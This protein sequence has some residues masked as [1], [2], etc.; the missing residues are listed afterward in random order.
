MLETFDLTRLINMVVYFLIT[1]SL[2]YLLSK[3]YNHVQLG[4]ILIAYWIFDT[5]YNCIL[6]ISGTVPI[7]ALPYQLCT[8]TMIMSAVAIRQKSEKLYQ[9]TI[10]TWISAL[11]SM[12][13][14]TRNGLMP[15]FDYHTVVFYVSHGIILLMQIYMTRV[16]R[17]KL[18]KYSFLNILIF[19]LLYSFSAWIINLFAGTNF[20]FISHPE[21]EN[22]ILA[23]LGTG[24]IYSVKIFFIGVLVLFIDELIIKFVFRIQ[25]HRYNVFLFRFFSGNH[26]Q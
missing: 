7:D 24:Y 21:H 23:S 10:Y 13:A 20:A 5:L 8:L 25:V 2:F 6:S 4:N 16:F 14:P 18:Y 3:R 17:F 12:F 15:F 22:V 26:K 1:A 19:L 9:I 11:V